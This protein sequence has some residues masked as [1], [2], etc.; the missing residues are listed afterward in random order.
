MAGWRFPEAYTTPAAEI[1]AARKSVALADVTPHGKLQIE[2]A[3]ALEAAR[4]AFGH[5]P[6]AIGAGVPVEG[7][8]LY[9]LRHD[10]FYLSTP[11]GG[12]GSAQA[13]LEAAIADNR[14]F[15]TVTDLTQGLAE[16]R[17]IGPHSRSL[18]SKVCALDF[19]P[20]AFPNL[21]AK[22]TSLAKTRQLILRRDFGNLPAFTC[23]GAQS[24]GAYVWEV[25]LEAG[26]EFGLVPM[27][28]AALAAL[29]KTL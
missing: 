4:A 24:L 26:Q 19:Q 1:A 16:M 28:I 17:V 12:E 3:A 8:Y 6:E 20:D 14:W 22:Q 15:V 5:A 7:G 18:L 21:A 27:G 23:V 11:P 25:M 10:Q 9:R 13:R 29:E 2:G